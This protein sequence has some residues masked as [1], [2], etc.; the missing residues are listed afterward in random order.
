M[1]EKTSRLVCFLTEIALAALGGQMDGEAIQAQEQGQDHGEIGREPQMST[2]PGPL[3]LQESAA[4]EG[5]SGAASR[6][7]GAG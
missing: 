1:D 5:Y 2:P 6:A 4:L 7:R 3:A